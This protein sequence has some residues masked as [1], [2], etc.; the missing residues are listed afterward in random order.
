MAETDQERGLA[1][2]QALQD[3]GVRVTQR[4]VWFLSAAH[5]DAEIGETLAAAERAL[6]R[7]R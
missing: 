7:V 2:C 4:G 5:G 6:A 1:F 3:E